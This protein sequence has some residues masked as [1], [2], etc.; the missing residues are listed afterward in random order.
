MIHTVVAYSVF[1]EKNV[2]APVMIIW[3][4]KVDIQINIR[5]TKNVGNRA[6][7]HIF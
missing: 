7:Y 6:K 3:I 5:D 4:T 1:K 2:A